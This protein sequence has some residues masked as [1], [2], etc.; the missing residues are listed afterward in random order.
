MTEYPALRRLALGTGVIAREAQ[1]ALDVIE[2]A[3]RTGWTVERAES[4]LRDREL[5]ALLTEQPCHA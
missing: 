4:T 3:D 5:V 1:R 2:L